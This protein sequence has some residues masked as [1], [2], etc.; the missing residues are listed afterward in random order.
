VDLDS[1]VSSLDGRLRVAEV[2]INLGQKRTWSYSFNS[3]S[4]E[5]DCSQHKNVVSFPRQG[6]GAKGGGVVIWL[7]DQSMPPILP[8]ADDGS[9]IK[10]I[11][12]EYGLLGELAEGLIALLA[13]RQVAGGSVVLLSSLANMAAAGTAGYISDLLAAIKLL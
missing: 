5:C 11:R 6:S 8:A 12:L 13:R 10:I 3:K 7:C 4:M 2:A 1:F 9:C